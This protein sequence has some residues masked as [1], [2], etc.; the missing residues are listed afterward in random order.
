LAG[1]GP[2][3]RALPGVLLAVGVVL[4]PAGEVGALVRGV[5]AGAWRSSRSVEGRHSVM[6]MHRRQKRLYGN[7]HEFG[8]GKRKGSSPY[9]RLGLVLPTES[10]RDLLRRPPHS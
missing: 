10:W 6:R 1:E 5:V 3:A 2:Q 7:L 4:A 9:G 8:A